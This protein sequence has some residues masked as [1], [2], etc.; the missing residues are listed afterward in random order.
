MLWILSTTNIIVPKSDE[1]HDEG[2]SLGLYH[3]HRSW[4]SSTTFQTSHGLKDWCS[5]YQWVEMN[6]QRYHCYQYVYQC[7]FPW[8]NFANCRQRNW[9]NF[10][11]FWNSVTSTDFSKFRKNFDI[12]KKKKKRK[13]NCGLERGNLSDITLSERL[14]HLSLVARESMHTNNRA[15]GKRIVGMS[16]WNAAIFGKAALSGA[17]RLLT[18][19]TATS[20]LFPGPARRRGVVTGPVIF[21]VVILVQCFP[22]GNIWLDVPGR[23]RQPCRHCFRDL[24]KYFSHPSLVLYS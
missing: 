15:V 10:G 9:E 22:V 11:I 21:P 13:K 14:V 6:A 18:W 12:K 24:R 20:S 8:R 4:N 23:E 2:W 17:G 16:V 3:C 19:E 5:F 1:G 7:F